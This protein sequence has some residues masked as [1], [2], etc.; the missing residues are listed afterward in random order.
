M[1][2]SNSAVDVD[3]HGGL[4]FSKLEPCEH[5]DGVG[6]WFGFDCAHLGDACIDIKAL[7]HELSQEARE[8]LARAAR[9][10]PSMTRGHFWLQYEV[11]KET[12]RLAEQLAI[13]GSK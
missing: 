8:E 1:E 7:Q 11:E 10:A 5:S 3:V 9:I 4:T 13:I 2:Y 6:W 12:E